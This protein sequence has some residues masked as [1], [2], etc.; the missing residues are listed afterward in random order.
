MSGL[1]IRLHGL[2]EKDKVFLVSNG[3]V[4]EGYLRNKRRSLPILFLSLGSYVYIEGDIIR[5]NKKEIE[6]EE[7]EVIPVMNYL[8]VSLSLP[9][10]I[11][12]DEELPILPYFDV[13]YRR[14]AIAIPE[15]FK[16]N[17][18]HLKKLGIIL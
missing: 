8:A 15:W 13:V 11:K 18:E 2:V 6:M 1:K 17:I 5:V 7:S 12:E 4:Y 16:S 9:E 3:V 10:K 14:P